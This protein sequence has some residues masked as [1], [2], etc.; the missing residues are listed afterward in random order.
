MWKTLV[1]MWKTFKEMWKTFV[2]KWKTIP[3]KSVKN[4]FFPCAFALCP[5]R[6][7][8]APTHEL[9]RITAFFAHD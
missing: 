4:S 1:L 6:G 9:E 2:E 8:S 7:N 3:K 5:V